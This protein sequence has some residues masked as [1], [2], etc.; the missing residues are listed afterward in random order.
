MD[1]KIL[2]F[3]H[4]F[5]RTLLDVLEKYQFTPGKN[6]VKNLLNDA[7]KYGELYSNCDIYNC[8]NM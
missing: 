8:M 6:E 3:I 5:N 7:K 4:F 2:I 1:K